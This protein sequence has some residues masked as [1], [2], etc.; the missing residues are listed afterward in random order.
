MD[1]ILSNLTSQLDN[2]NRKH[3]RQPI[4]LE[5]AANL[6]QVVVGLHQ[7]SLHSRTQVHR[8]DIC[9]TIPGPPA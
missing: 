3:P 6:P 7:I 9:G 2:L 5:D 8:M 1:Q 4:P